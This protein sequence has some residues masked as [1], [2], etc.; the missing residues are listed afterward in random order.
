[1]LL[2]MGL[3]LAVGGASVHGW[4]PGSRRHT[5]ARGVGHLIRPTGA[6]GRGG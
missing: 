1:M 5:G 6:G 2:Q 4:G 3:G